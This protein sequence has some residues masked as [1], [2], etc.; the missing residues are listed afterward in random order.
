MAHRPR[1]RARPGA[2]LNFLLTDGR[3]IWA[4]R[5]G[6]TL[7]YRTGHESVRVASEPDT[8]AVP[9]AEP[10]WQEV[11]EESLLVATASS[12]RTVPLVQPPPPPRGRTGEGRSVHARRS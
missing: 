3:T 12:V 11:P 5:R 7:W 10:G 2:R 6:D 9:G 4:T 1:R 8:A